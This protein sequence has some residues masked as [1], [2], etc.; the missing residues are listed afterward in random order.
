[1]E[2][3][4]IKYTE[5]AREIL[6]FSKETRHMNECSS[7]EEFKSLLSEEYI[8]ENLEYVFGTIGS[9]WEFIDYIFVIKGVTRAF[10]HQLVR[11]RIG[12]SFAQ[13]SLRLVTDS[14]FDYLA[15]GVLALDCESGKKYA[16]GMTGVRNVYCEL[17]QD[18]VPQQDARGIL[19]TNILTNILFKANL[20]ALSELI[21]ARLCYRTQGEFQDVAKLMK[22]EVLFVH[23]WAEEILEVCCIKNSLCPWK[24]YDK[25]P[26]KKKF[27][28]LKG[29][30]EDE[31]VDMK[32][33]FYSLNFSPQPELKE[34]R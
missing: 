2:V 34:K 30:P 5:E 20:R 8:S 26:L 10:T 16:D 4:L 14:E 33:Y 28:K 13:Q 31:K 15:S 29:I 3:N 11:H 7:F 18:G 21:S 6:L 32:K 9:S 19:P 22:K 24:N 12:T 27:P 23:P 17:L 1:M 25:C